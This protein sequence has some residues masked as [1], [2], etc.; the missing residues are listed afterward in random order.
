VNTHRSP[1]SK[2]WE[3]LQ[4]FFDRWKLKPE[5]ICIILGISEETYGSWVLSG[6]MSLAPRIVARCDECS[7]LHEA[8]LIH[9]PE[10]RA[11]AWVQRVNTAELFKGRTAIRTI[12]EELEHNPT[13][14]RDIIRY[15]QA[16]AL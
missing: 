13:I 8:L 10:D 9:F 1:L 15:I 4:E 12:C 5:E 14:I 3:D 6:A 11:F 2:A 7:Q 16:Q